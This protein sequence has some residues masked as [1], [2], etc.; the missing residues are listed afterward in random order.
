MTKATKKPAKK[1]SASD[2]QRAAAA[3]AWA[4]IWSQRASE[5][6]ATAKSKDGHAEVDAFI[7]G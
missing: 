6:A 3:D 1:I 2:R 5:I 4:T 7:N